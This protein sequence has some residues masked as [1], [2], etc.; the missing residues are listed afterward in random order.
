M[1]QIAFLNRRSRK[2]E[3]HP[4]WEQGARATDLEVGQRVRVQTGSLAGLCGVLTSQAEDGKW[5]VDINGVARG[6]ALCIR[7]HQLTRV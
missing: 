7:G 4:T 5:V 1:E 6:V 2:D 3:R